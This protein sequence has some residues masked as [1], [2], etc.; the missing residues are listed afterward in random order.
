MKPIILVL[1]CLALASVPALPALSGQAEWRKLPLR[2]P[3]AIRGICA[4]GDSL[5]EASFSGVR[6]SG[7]GGAT[8]SASGSGLRPGKAVGV[9]AGRAH[10]AACQGNILFQSGDGG[11]TWQARDSLETGNFLRMD[12]WGDTLFAWHAVFGTR[13]PEG[14]RFSVDDGSTWS[15]LPIEAM[16]M[17]KPRI[18]G[19]DTFSISNSTLYRVNSDGPKVMYT[20]PA[21]IQEFTADANGIFVI[22]D[23][24]IFR[25]IDPQ[26]PWTRIATPMVPGA[27]ISGVA[28]DSECI[29]VQTPRGISLSRNRGLDWEYLG[30]NFAR[31]A[32]QSLHLGNGFLYV[33]RGWSDA[34]PRRYSLAE[35][36][37]DSLSLPGP[38]SINSGA[39]AVAGDRIAYLMEVSGRD[40]VYLSH[41]RGARFQNAGPS[42][43]E[44]GIWSRLFLGRRSDITIVDNSDFWYSRNDGAGWNAGRSPFCPSLTRAH[45]VASGDSGVFIYGDHLWLLPPGALDCGHIQ[46]ALPDGYLK[47]DPLFYP[48]TSLAAW[49]GSLYLG[50]TQGLWVWEEPSGTTRT[51]PKPEAIRHAPGP[52]PRQGLYPVRTWSRSREPGSGTS[53]TAI[54]ARGARRH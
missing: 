47:E 25:A 22:S 13:T 26:G 52:G 40:S 34:A 12:A 3:D 37:W 10:L 43:L 32:D 9:A 41:D 17:S 16:P 24:L 23:S 42:P 36:K 31:A 29:A 2:E 4:R 38:A 27:T 54:D 1:G 8:W 21:P 44:A 50:L 39:F 15:A 11:R 35:G 20:F 19:A 7:D 53:Q 49:G 33:R 51:G 45:H 14:I 6:A 5:W 28:A 30:R 48:G 18:F 46:I